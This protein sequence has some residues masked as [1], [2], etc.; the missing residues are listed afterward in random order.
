MNLEQNL[1]YCSGYPAYVIAPTDIAQAYE[2]VR[3]K[4]I[5]EQKLQK[6]SK[7]S[8][9]G[10]TQ[11]FD[12]QDTNAGHGN[13]FTDFALDAITTE[14]LGRISTIHTLHEGSACYLKKLEGKYEQISD[15]LRKRGPSYW[16]PA[17]NLGQIYLSWD[18]SG[19][20]DVISEIY[21]NGYTTG[22]SG[23]IHSVEL[24]LM[25]GRCLKICGDVFHPYN[26]RVRIFPPQNEPNQVEPRVLIGIECL[27]CME[28]RRFYGGISM[29]KFGL[30]KVSDVI[31][32]T[33][34]EIVNKITKSVRVLET[35]Y[36]ENLSLAENQEAL[37]SFTYAI[38]VPTLNTN[39]DEYKGFLTS[40]KPI[41]LNHLLWRKKKSQQGRSR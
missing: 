24:L 10:A 30:A 38:S 35:D 21:V 8:W 26:S 31:N 6:G 27:T 1:T 5:I 36:S 37:S 11:T 29:I 33:P 2:G 9:Y 28:E 17:E 15:S 19:E 7:I 4:E 13:E 3:R 39:S 25:N 16:D 14:D 18:I 20:Q 40:N 23:R 41:S 32:A 34:Q 12:L 22:I